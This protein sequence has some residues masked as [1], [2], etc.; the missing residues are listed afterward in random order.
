[1]RLFRISIMRKLLDNL[2]GREVKLT[3]QKEKSK[4]ARVGAAA[5][6]AIPKVIPEPLKK[7][8]QKA[9]MNINY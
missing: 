8:A 4:E 6:M 1:M 7:G 2:R 3:W 5:G 9:T